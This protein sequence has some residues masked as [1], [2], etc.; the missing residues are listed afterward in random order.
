M[1]LYVARHGETLSNIERRLTGKDNDSSLTEKGIEQAKRLG[2]SLEH[3]IF[4]AVYSSPLNRAIDTANIAFGNKYKIYIDDRLAEIGLGVM[5][6]M[7]YDEATLNFPE[8][9]MLFFTDPIS[10]KPSADGECLNDMIK[11]IDLFLGDIEKKDYNKVFIMTHGYALRVMY[12]CTI[13]K[14]ISAIAK[15]PYYSN[16]DIG[17]YM[18]DNG[19]WKLI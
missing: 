19:K 12:A 17:R 8:S 3:I 16:C 9:G 4:D 13:D 7:T 6:G 15:S 1:E 10:Y 5:D 14:S 2:K 11:R 18:F